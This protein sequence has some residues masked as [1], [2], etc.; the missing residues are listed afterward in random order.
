MTAEVKILVTSG[1]QISDAL[2]R[3]SELQDDK[4][5]SEKQLALLIAEIDLTLKLMA[6]VSTQLNCAQV[7]ALY[8]RAEALNAAL[9]QCIGVK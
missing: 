4:D 8:A 5:K 1:E 3:V 9:K 6:E 2:K 7:A